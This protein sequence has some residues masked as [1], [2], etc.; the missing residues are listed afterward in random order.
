MMDKTV[1]AAFLEYSPNP[2]WLAD[3]DG[4]CVYANRALR[5]I[6][7]TSADRLCDL[8][9][10]ELVTDEER[11]MSSTL[12]QEA[13][14][15]HQPYRARFF[16][17]GRGSASGSAVDVVG[18][19]H[20]APDGSEMWLFT[21]VPSLLSSNALPPIEA[22]LQVTLNALPIQA[23]YARASGALAFVNTATA[24]YLGLPSDHPLRSAGDSEAPWDAH[25]VFLHPEDQAQS[26]RN[27]AEYIRT[28][29]AQ[30]DHFRVLG[31]NGDYRWFLSHAEPIRDSK[32]NIRYWVGV[33]I[34][35]DDGK[36]ASEALDT[37]RE[38]IARA[39][40][41]A[42][43]AE[44]S[45]SLSH[46][47][48]Q[49]VAA[50]VANARAALNWLSSENLNISQANAALEGVVRDGMSVGNVVHEMRE[51]L[52]HRRPNPRA[53]DMN[54]LVEQVI[55]LQAPDIRDKRI[56]INCELDPALPLAF[57]DG[58]QI[59][60]VLFNLLVETCEAI[61]R[62]ERPKE[63]TIKT[64]VFNDNVY[65]EVQANG[66]CIADLEYLLEAI[67]ADESR[68]TVVA[69]AVSR[70]IVEAQGGTLEVVRL[71]EGATCVRI[72][73]PRFIFS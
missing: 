70:S 64:S 29:N 25:L 31:A 7:A 16:L 1:V 67:F 13:R 26:S 6:S 20:V 3:S 33:N 37:A 53:I 44:I 65:L 32:G 57:A 11:N 54:A 47:I 68:G 8:N 60:Q 23:W 14:V 55:T 58:A 69:L 24:N 34:D 27:W 61:S 39:T 38:R 15:H 56:V 18:A 52:D 22:N 19:G 40:Q 36:R 62:C 73:L 10:L 21:A 72:E 2:T 51:F 46:K 50:V 12:W 45:A 43:I 30:E 5:E 49:P 17:R 63:L 35:I 4:R 42:A 48:V 28:G 9:W 41:S 71:E 59:Q 66:V